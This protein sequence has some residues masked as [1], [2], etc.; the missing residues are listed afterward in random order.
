MENKLFN[1]RKDFKESH[2]KGSLKQFILDNGGY[3]GIID[4]FG[5]A[6]AFLNEMKKAGYSRSY[7][8]VVKKELKYKGY[9]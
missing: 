4:E 7:L 9:L 8:Y 3:Q 1:I 6:I 5:N 2:K